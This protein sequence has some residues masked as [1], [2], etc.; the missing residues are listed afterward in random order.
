MFLARKNV[1]RSVRQLC[2][3]MMPDGSDCGNVN[4]IDVSAGA[5]TLGIKR[6]SKVYADTYY[7]PMCPRCSTRQQITV[8]WGALA[9]SEV[10]TPIAAQRGTQNWIAK[11]LH[12]SAFI[13]TA[14]ATDVNALWTVGK[15]PE[16]ILGDPPSDWE[17]L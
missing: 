11:G 8:S 1:P 3:G 15:T 2:S 13:T 9:P 5:V 12:D 14:C 6:G 7:M 10:G 4:D 17:T 16:V